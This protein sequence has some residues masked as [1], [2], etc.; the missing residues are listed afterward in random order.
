MESFGQIKTY[1]L[2][3]MSNAAQQIEIFRHFGEDELKNHT[4]EL[5]TRY[6]NRELASNDL[7][8]QVL[9]EHSKSFKRIRR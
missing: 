4:E 8:Q 5:N 1:K 2:S 7:K 3:T 6:Q 9:K